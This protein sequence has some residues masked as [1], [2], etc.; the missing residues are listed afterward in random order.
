MNTAG[1]HISANLGH[2]SYF[3]REDGI[4]QVEGKDHTYSAEELKQI[5]GQL[6]DICKNHKYPCLI[7]AQKSSMLDS[8]AIKYYSTRGLLSFMGPRAYVLKSRT[9]RMLGAIFISSGNNEKPAKAFSNIE[10]AVEWLK[11]QT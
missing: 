6:K 2:S 5:V 10:S 7:V 8:G 11:R 3:C 1:E 4:I 9:Q